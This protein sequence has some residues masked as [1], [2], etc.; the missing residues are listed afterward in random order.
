MFI[1]HVR[2]NLCGRLFGWLLLGF[3]SQQIS[4][5]S[6]PRHP[7]PP[8]VRYLDPKNIP[9]KTSN[10][11]TNIWMSRVLLIGKMGSSTGWSWPPQFTRRFQDWSSPSIY[12][13]KKLLIGQLK[14]LCLIISEFWRIIR[15][16]ENHSL[17]DLNPP[18][19]P[20]TQEQIRIA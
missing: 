5:E 18:N 9:K 1:K 3:S 13:K 2:G 4:S 17:Y 20:T 15:E 16:M 6:Y 7:G 10:L 14:V 12:L 11:R 8:E 19:V